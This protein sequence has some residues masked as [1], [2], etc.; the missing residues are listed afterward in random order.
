[1]EAVILG[2]ARPRKKEN[3]SPWALELFYF[4][5][6]QS[7]GVFKEYFIFSLEKACKPLF[8]LMDDCNKIMISISYA[9]ELSNFNFDALHY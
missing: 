7:L 1:M 3:P 5:L 8:E 6:F 2:H 9:R 4:S